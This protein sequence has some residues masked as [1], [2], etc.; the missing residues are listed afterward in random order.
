MPSSVGV[1]P[2][3]DFVG[4][5]MSVSDICCVTPAMVVAELKGRVG[6]RHVPL[7]EGSIRGAVRAENLVSLVV[8]IS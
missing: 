8:G 1:G 4:F 3:L 7:A 2:S 5:E 6:T